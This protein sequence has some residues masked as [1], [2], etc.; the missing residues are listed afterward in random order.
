LYSSYILPI[1]FFLTFFCCFFLSHSIPFSGG[2]AIEVNDKNKVRYLD[3]WLR[4]K[5]E[6]EIDEATK[7][8]T[9][10]L[11]SVVPSGV[12]SMFD[13]KDLQRLL[14]G[15]VLDE[16]AL[17]DLFRHIIY[18]A[19]GG[20]AERTKLQSQFEETMRS[21]TPRERQNTFRFVTSLDRVPPGGCGSLV[22]QF[23]VEIDTRT[24]KTLEHLPEA[25]TC[26]NHVLMPHYPDVETMMERFRVAGNDGLEYHYEYN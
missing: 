14:G 17:D 13:A 16:D 22:P 24:N 6:S 1:L 9:D 3:L 7:W 2:S 23:T 19:P 4:H 15:D 5:L 12:L 11:T 20:D 10:G 18:D 26:M 25:Q 8:F 21:F